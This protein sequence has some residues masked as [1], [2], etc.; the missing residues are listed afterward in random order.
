MKSSASG[1][2]VR[3]AG[4]AGK[5]RLIECLLRQ[6][7]VAGQRTLANALCICGNLIHITA[8]DKLTEQGTPENDIYFIVAG[9]VAIVVNGRQ[10]A[11]RGAGTHIG[12]MALID[13]AALRSASVVA[14]EECTV[15]RVTEESFT[16]L[17]KRYPDVWRRIAAEI[18]ARLRERSK[19][20]RPPHAEPTV[21]IGSSSEG[22]RVAQ[23]IHDGLSRRKCI[24]TLWSNG[25]FQLSNTTIEDLMTFSKETD[26][27]AFV[28]TA[29]DVTASRGRRKA[30]PRDN[31]VF[32]IGLFMGAIGRERT[33]VVT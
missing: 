23:F 26:F 3:F 14:L 27:A 8:P 31:V 28:V 5:A 6:P 25:V 17:S 33:F 10:V 13:A 24:P 32:E 19:F 1:L 4:L 22:M 2:A 9:S 30:S 21:F 16:R 18:G 12:E 20:H 7:I 29:D 11:V 15:L